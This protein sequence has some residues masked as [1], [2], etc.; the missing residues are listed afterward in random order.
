MARDGLEAVEKA[1]AYN[2]DIILMDINTPRLT[3]SD[4]TMRL[5][6]AG[7]VNPI[8]ALTASDIRKIDTENFTACLRKPIQMA[9]LLAQIK[10]HLS[11]QIT[12]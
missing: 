4:A 11:E 12:E 8:V 2:P 10:L 1:L 6:Q 9:E 5:R 3:G 7:F